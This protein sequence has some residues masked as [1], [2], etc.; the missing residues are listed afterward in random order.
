MARGK[1]GGWVLVL[2]GLEN[3]ASL[4]DFDHATRERN[5]NRTGQGMYKKRRDRFQVEFVIA[6]Q[7][8]RCASLKTGRG[9]SITSLTK[10]GGGQSRICYQGK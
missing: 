1:G 4:N 2:E 8:G 3:K 10:D 7:A 6:Q 9:V 5:P